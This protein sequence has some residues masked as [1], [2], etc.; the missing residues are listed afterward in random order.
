MRRGRKRVA[1]SLAEAGI[2]RDERPGRPG[3]GSGR[4][5][6]LDSRRAEGLHR[7]VSADTVGYVVLSAVREEQWKPVGY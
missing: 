6:G 4:P 1:D 2:P 3:A 5:G 7:L